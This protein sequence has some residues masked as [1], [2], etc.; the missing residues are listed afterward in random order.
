MELEPG[1]SR[2]LHVGDQAGGVGAEI[3]AEESLGAG[4]RSG[5]EAE[6]P[7]QALERLAHGFVVVDDRYGPH[8]PHA[9]PFV[10]SVERNLARV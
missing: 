3:R 10:C 8:V 4:E 7:E 6:R 5:L 1:H 9:D 2:H